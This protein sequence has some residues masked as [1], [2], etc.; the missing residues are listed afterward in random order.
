MRILFRSLGK[1]GTL[2]SSS[3]SH[4]FQSGYVV[5]EAGEEVGEHETGGGEEIMVL[6]EGTA[7]VSHGRVTETARS[8]A[9]VL[10]PAHT[11]HNVRNASR[12]PLRYVY[13]Y[14]MAMDDSR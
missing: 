1:A 12:V 7:E 2:V 3:D 6:L 10:V 5:L 4:Q 13:I 8:P 9:V 14:N 11:S